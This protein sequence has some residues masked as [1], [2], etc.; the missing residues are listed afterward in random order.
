MAS[1]RDPWPTMV[2]IGVLCGLAIGAVVVLLVRGGRRSILG[3]GPEL[4]LGDDDIDLLL[5]PKRRSRDLATTRFESSPML[6]PMRARP[7][8][9][10]SAISATSP[11]L[12]FQ[13]TG[14]IDWLITVRVFGPPG[15]FAT[16]L[17]GAEAG[18]GTMIPAGGHQP[19]QVPRG[20]FL[21]AQGS[22]TGVQVSVA[23]G[24]K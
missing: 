20:E 22:T 5:P 9:R 7:L 3:G 12:L 10:S 18:N 24:E 8:A 2:L 15:S 6:A 4:E 1:D 11:T 14:R 16:F 19:M 23:G 21:Y 17:I 13:A